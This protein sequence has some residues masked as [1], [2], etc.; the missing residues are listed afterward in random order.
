MR[1]GRIRIRGWDYAYL[2][3]G[4]GPLVLLIHG[5]PDD[6]NTWE[7]QMRAFAAAGYRVV[8]PFIRGYP[9]TEVRIDGYYDRATLASDVV[10]LATALGDGGRFRLVGHDWGAAITYGVLGAFPERVE[11]AAALAVPHPVEVRRSL[12]RDPRQ[13]VRSFHWFLF[14]MPWLPERLLRAFDAQAV[15]LLWRLWSPEFDD[16]DHVRRIR[17]KFLHPGVVEATLAYYRSL[18]RTA[19]MDPALAEVRGR[20]DKAIPSPTL[21]LMGGH[22]RLRREMLPRQTDLFEGPYETAVVEGAGH[23]LHREKPNEV[24]DLLREWFGRDA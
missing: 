12:R 24:N 23:F 7:H 14:Q 16:R 6:A 22:D 11:R 4:D 8:A 20:L 21:V 18:F 13:V 17:D 15:E 10:E 19:Y 2:E 5:Y 1:E 9:P 3:E